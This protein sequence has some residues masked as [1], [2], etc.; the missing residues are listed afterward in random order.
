MKRN[1]KC[2]SAK[3]GAVFKGV[4]KPQRKSEEVVDRRSN[5][6]RKRPLQGPI[7]Q[8]PAE[9][10]PN[11]RTGMRPFPPAFIAKIAREGKI[12]AQNNGRRA[13]TRILR[14]RYPAARLTTTTAD[15]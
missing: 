15:R 2:R 8:E 6:I 5:N 3:A 10:K 1:F 4:V 7:N 9:K 14:E 13:T 12:L 11:R